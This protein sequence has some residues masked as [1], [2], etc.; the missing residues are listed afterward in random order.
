[1]I[2]KSEIAVSAVIILA[3]ASTALA[4]D[5]GPPKLDIEYACH[6][7]V[8]AISVSLGETSNDFG[9]CMDDEKEARAQLEKDWAKYPA[10]DKAACI[11]PKE[12][13]PAYVE[14]LTCLEMDRD[15]RVTRKGQPTVSSSADKCPVVRYL[16][17]G[18]IVSVNTAC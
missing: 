4:K 12:Y 11:L 16:Q 1:M 9:A 10:S 17:D 15:V 14:W 13:I 7:S 6:A 8:A 18:T 3:V 2:N 5:G